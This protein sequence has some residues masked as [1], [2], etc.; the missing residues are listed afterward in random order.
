[1]GV[2]ATDLDIMY[3]RIWDR[4]DSRFA[5]YALRSTKTAVFLVIYDSEIRRSSKISSLY[6]VSRYIRS[7]YDRYLL[8]V[9]R[10]ETKLQHQICS[11]YPVARYNRS[12]LYTIYNVLLFCFFEV[13][14]RLE[15]FTERTKPSFCECYTCFRY[16]TKTGVV[17]ILAFFKQRPI[18]SRIN[19]KLSPTPF[20]C[21]T[22]T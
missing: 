14:E 10:Y 17:L 15:S 6:L 9:F 11:L 18:L 7:R 1:M 4:V 16:E 19:V 22:W 2:G 21:H 5:Y 12:R 20:E 13:R 8:C 3:R